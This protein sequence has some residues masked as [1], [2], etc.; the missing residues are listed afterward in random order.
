MW[1]VLV[2]NELILSPPTCHMTDATKYWCHTASGIGPIT[3]N[4]YKSLAENT[5]HYFFS[6]FFYHHKDKAIKFIQISKSRG[7]AMI[8]L[9][10]FIGGEYDGWEMISITVKDEIKIVSK[11][12]SLCANRSSLKRL[13][14]Y[15][16]WDVLDRRS[17]RVILSFWFSVC[18]YSPSTAYLCSPQSRCLT[19]K[20]NGKCCAKTLIFLETR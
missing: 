13:I 7:R 1:D 3:V 17:S 12:F 20:K 14:K 5:F 6:F 10:P 16:F 11:T 18:M 15:L 2:S 8:F 9:G 4:F 19:V